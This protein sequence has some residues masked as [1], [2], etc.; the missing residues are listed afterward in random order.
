[1]D[2]NAGHEIAVHTVAVLVENGLKRRQRHITY[3]DGE[4]RRVRSP[5]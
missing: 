3:N 5:W 2:A 4:P 1:V